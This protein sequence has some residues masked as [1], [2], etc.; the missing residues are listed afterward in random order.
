LLKLWIEVFCDLLSIS[1][2]NLIFKFSVFIKFLFY[3]LHCLTYSFSF[4]FAFYLNLSMCLF[5]FSL[6]SLGCLYICSSFTNFYYNHY[7]VFF[8]I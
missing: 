2:Q 8:E 3:I 6:N 7:F 5:M 4:L 1:F